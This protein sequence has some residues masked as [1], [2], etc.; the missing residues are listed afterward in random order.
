MGASIGIIAAII[1]AT[2][3][4]ASTA[5]GII[6]SSSS[7]AAASSASK[8]AAAIQAAATQSATDSTNAL[9]EEQTKSN[10][11]LSSKLESANTAQDAESSATRDAER[12]KI[13]A[14]TTSNILTSPLGTSGT[15]ATIGN[16]L[17]GQSSLS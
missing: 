13:L 9:I 10:N 2:A 3:S 8:K 17:L 15:A 5:Y 7:Q 16:T 1:G 4:A 11:E 14:S 6:S 12:K